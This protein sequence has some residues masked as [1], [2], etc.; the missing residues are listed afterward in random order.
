VPGGL[1]VILVKPILYCGTSLVLACDGL[2]SKAWGLNGRPRVQLSGE[3]DDW[4]WLADGELGEAPEDPGTYEGGHA[5]PR[6]HSDPARQNKWCARECERS[7]M[8]EVGPLELPDFSAR[9]PNYHGR[10]PDRDRA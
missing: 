10:R 1:T 8:V 9:W 3:E 2:C 7:E 4:E 6:D 5:K